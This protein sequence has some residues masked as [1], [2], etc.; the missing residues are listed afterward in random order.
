MTPAQCAERIQAI[1]DTGKLSAREQAA[2]MAAAALIR[3]QAAAIADAD[4]RSRIDRTD[5]VSAR[6]S[7]SLMRQL[8]AAMLEVT[9]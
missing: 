5:C 9:E 1:C 6:A 4:L 3:Q 8:A 2:L 7:V